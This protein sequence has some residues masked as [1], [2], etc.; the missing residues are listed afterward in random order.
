[1]RHSSRRQTLL[2]LVF[3]VLVVIFMTA[4]RMG[5]VSGVSMQPT[6]QD[7]QIVLVRR[8]GTYG[9]KLRRGDVVLV[10]NEHDVIIK[11]VF[12]LPGE[13]IDNSFPD[14]LRPTLFHGLQD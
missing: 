6:Y 13:E 14:V 2:I 9:R 8:I 10:R 3:L 7:G 5:V 1:M 12:R 4:F 11:R